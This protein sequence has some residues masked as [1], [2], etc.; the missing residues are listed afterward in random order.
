MW[1]LYI[2]FCGIRHFNCYV[3]S[4]MVLCLLSI[5]IKFAIYATWQNTY[6]LLGPLTQIEKYLG[7]M[8]VIEVSHFPD[9][10]IFPGVGVH[11][12]ILIVQVPP[13]VPELIS[14]SNRK[15]FIQD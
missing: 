15:L 8:H 7:R 2:S 14:D 5:P 11:N 3:K 6:S 4:G 1:D 13:N 12:I 9:V 10:E